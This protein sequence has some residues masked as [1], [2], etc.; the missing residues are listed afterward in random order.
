M[1]MNVELKGTNIIIL[2]SNFNP[3]I[4]TKDWLISHNIFEK[5]PIN[6]MNNNVIS[7]FEDDDYTLEIDL[8]RLNYILK[9][10]E[11][12]N[13]EYMSSKINKYVD[14]LPETPYTAIGYNVYW[15]LISDK[16]NEVAELLKSKYCHKFS[17]INS[18]LETDNFDYGL[19]FSYSFSDIVI[20]IKILPIFKSFNFEISF[21]FHKE[22][23]NIIKNKEMNQFIENL[24]MYYSKAKKVLDE[25]IKEKEIL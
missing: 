20:S 3:A 24:K 12:I 15:H 8:Q 10:P 13:L 21:N 18:I 16:E 1:N 11:Y 19:F 14:A 5:E 4:P 6:F 7:L 25:I 9:K 2:A 23:K 22:L 17:D